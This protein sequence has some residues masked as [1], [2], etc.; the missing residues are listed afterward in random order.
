[1]IIRIQIGD[2]SG[3]GHGKCDDFFFDSNLS[4]E[5]VREAYFA[6]KKKYPKLSPESFCSDYEDSTV[7][8]SLVENAKVAGFE[9]FPE[10]FG[11]EEM[12]EYT[13]WFC[14]L[15]DSKLTLKIRDV[16]PTLAFYGSDK[17]KRHIRFIGYGLLM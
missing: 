4:Q 14:M 11:T 7:P 8:E 1:M 9:I 3:D 6:A 17:K 2:W 16:V 5:E 10:D 12:A 15:G 13:A